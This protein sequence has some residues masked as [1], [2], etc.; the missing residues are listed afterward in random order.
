M[1]TNYQICRRC[2]MDTSD[3]NIIFSYQGICNH[4]LDYDINFKSDVLSGNKARRHIIQLVNIVKQDSIG[5]K[6]HCLV[7]LSG[8]VDST[9]TLYKVVSLGLKPLVV[10]LDNGWNSA[11]AVQNI[12][13]AVS[14]LKVDLFT[15][16]LDWEEFRDLQ[17]A[18]L[19]AS[20]PDIEIPTDHAIV[21]TIYLAAKKFKIK[22]II[23]GFNRKTE[24]HLPTAW[25]QGH[26]DW[27]YIKSVNSLF[28][29]GSLKTFPKINYWQNRN[30]QKRF[31]IFNILNYLDYS[32]S[33]AMT[34]L[35]KQIDWQYYG[36]KHYESI[37][38]RFY[39]GYLLP[40]KFGYDKR[41]MHYSSLI[42]AGEISRKKVLY[43]LK[44]ESYDVLLQQEDKNY[45]IKKLALTKTEFA[46]I[47]KAPVKSF[48]D[49]P[50]YQKI[51]NRVKPFQ[52]IFSKK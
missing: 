11:Q 16:V 28:G 43:I 31:T 33:T 8:G 30:F 45:V 27:K 4:C 1:S 38:T 40:K 39:Q 19:R 50:S 47:M 36:G 21:A 10:H 41:R 32:K 52:N 25:S 34:E 29:K 7:G 35:N 24:S 46:N 15:K 3:P 14:K 37:F 49:Y 22:N 18:F 48:W 5:Q 44:N 17:V 12:Y 9:Y 13:H 26:Y 51:V 23:L 20:T 42:C 6:Y 2:V